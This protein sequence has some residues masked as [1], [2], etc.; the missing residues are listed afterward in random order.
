VA[1]WHVAGSLDRL[2]AQLNALA[3]NRSKA[4]D[5]SIGDAAHATRDSDHNPWY[6]APDNPTVT[7]RDFTHDPAGGLD[8]QWLRDRLIASR[9][10]R[11]KYVIWNRQITSGAG[12]TL[13]W[14]A[15]PYTG[16]NPHDHHVHVSVVASPA[17]EDRRDWNLGGNTPAPTGKHATVRRGSTGPDVELLQRFLGVIRPGEPGYGTFG[18]LTERAVIRYQTMRGLAP[19]GVVGERTWREI[20]L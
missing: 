17:C 14:T 18:P 8:G 10:S 1:G 7:A 9:D 15:K 11:I 13:P 5:G 6:G 16:T 20:G 4:S 3:P 12:G 2:L 19:D